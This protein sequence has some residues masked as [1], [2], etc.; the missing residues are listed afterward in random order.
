MGYG[1]Q[2][3]M[4][5][6]CALMRTTTARRRPG[7]SVVFALILGCSWSAAAAQGPSSRA[8]VSA[9]RAALR[10][11]PA[12]AAPVVD[13]LTTNTE[14]AILERTTDWCR[15]RGQAGAAPGFI[16]C[17]FL[18]TAKL[19]IDAIEAR[20]HDKGLA[21]RERLDWQSRAFWVSPSL[22]RLEAVG[23]AMEEAFLSEQI[24]E[25]EIDEGKLLRPHH[26]EFDAMKT[27]LE[28]G[29]SVPPPV[30]SALAI[31][32]TSELLRAAMKR[33]ALP[34]IRPSFF[35][36]GEPLFAVALFPFTLKRSGSAG[37]GLTDALSAAHGVSFRTR[38]V[39]P[40]SMAHSGPVG[41]WDIG[42]ASA[43][44][45]RAAIL[46]G[47]TRTGASTGLSVASLVTP[48][49]HQPCTGEAMDLNARP[50]NGRWRSA[51]VAWVGKPAPP[52]DA[53]VTTRQLGGAGKRGKLVIETIDLDRDGVPDFSVWAGQEPPDVEVETYWKAVFGNIG[54]TW[55]L[56]AFHQETDCT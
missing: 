36:G 27:R 54:G 19:T 53:L 18:G 21:S 45:D 23:Y 50:L 6:A 34:P 42:R 7:V 48:L 26:A 13:Y 11:Q 28:K 39:R 30:S 52:A 8:Y 38:I 25:R 22:R 24:H 16:A 40:V 29:V 49:G 46:Y 33:A 3:A 10:A 44:F 47:I 31:D 41:V 1:V 17:R 15:V 12:A 56:L 43:T 32:E 5:E 51:I 2:P 9:S 37:P 4:E 20:L 35:P 55:V 14:V